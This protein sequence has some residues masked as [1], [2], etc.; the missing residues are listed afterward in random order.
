MRRGEVWLAEVGRKA[1]PVVVL[2]RNEVLDVR[3]LVTVAEVTTN[4][5]GSTVEVA[6]DADE[7]GLGQPSV[8]NADGVHTIA[9]TRLTRRFGTVG[10]RELHLVCQA[11]RRAIGC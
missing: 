2:T 4:I 7:A 1:R 9:Q 8:V 3:Q 6:I 5:R 10:E 11:V